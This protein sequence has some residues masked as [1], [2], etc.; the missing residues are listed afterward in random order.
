MK[1]SPERNI[2]SPQLPKHLR[3]GPFEAVHDQAEYASLSVS[4]SNLVNQTASN[5]VFEQTLFRRVVFN[6]THLDKIRL[7][8]VR[9]EAS[10]LSGADWERALFVESNSS[11][12]G[13]WEPSCPR[14][15]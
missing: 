11:D 3:A 7:T 15:V 5:V 14:L 10:D 4:G 13:S 1:S 6:R 9:L 12:V 8:D 2:Q